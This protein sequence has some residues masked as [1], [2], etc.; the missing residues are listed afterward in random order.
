MSV[1]HIVGFRFKQG[2]AVSVQTDLSDAF[3]KLKQECVLPTTNAPYITKLVGGAQ[4]SPEGLAKGMQVGVNT[5]DSNVPSLAKRFMF[6][7]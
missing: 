5:I 4:N 6:L 1:Q 2:V 3:V 7:F